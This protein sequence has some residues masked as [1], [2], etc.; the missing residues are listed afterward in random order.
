MNKLKIFLLLILVFIIIIC[1]GCGSE[2]PSAP[3]DGDDSSEI[4]PVTEESPPPA[5]EGTL[6]ETPQ[7]PD[8]SL[9][10]PDYLQGD[11]TE[12]FSIIEETDNAVTYELSGEERSEAAAQI[13]LQIE[14]SINQVLSDKEHYPGITGVSVNE[15]C[16]EFN[17]TFS[18]VSLSL[19]ESTLPMS[20]Y[21]VGNKFQLYQGTPEEELLTTVNY[22]DESTGEIFFTGTSL[23]M[24]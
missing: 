22:I 7:F 24:Q 3:S 4:S 6:A 10:V 23:E 13:G 16:T 15:D 12:N 2:R 1:T 19:Y 8:G 14:E 21:I 5:L 20:L 17:V 18:G 11:E 9:N